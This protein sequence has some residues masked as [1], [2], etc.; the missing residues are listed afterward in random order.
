VIGRRGF[1]HGAALAA[2]AVPRLAHARVGGAAKLPRIGVIGEVSPVPWTVR[3]AV[4]EIECRWSGGRRDALPA[5]AAELAARR[6]DVI[7]AI[8]AGPARAARHATRAIPIVFVSGGDPVAQGLVAAMD[9]PGSNAT[10]LA[11]LS[12]AEMSR[13]RLA[14]LRRVAPS[15]RRVAALLNPDAAGDESPAAELSAAAARS[16]IES[17]CFPARTAED[18]DRAFAAMPPDGVDGVAV[19]PDALFAIHAR[20]IAELAATHGLPAVYGARSFAE[21]GGLLAICG[22][23]A[24]LIR[25]TA[26]M[27]ARVLAGSDPATLAVERFARTE[28][29]VNAT[30]ARALGLAIP[31]SLLARADAVI[32]T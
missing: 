9:R 32:E 11:T 31:R 24:E 3:T 30:A 7:V 28:L 29:T 20:R 19:L 17:R 23:T 10:G 15:V 27:V 16:G 8:G 13:E 18:I 4:A 25:R 14:A 26:S 21:A 22:D 2:L 12:E 1:L 6:V 5:L